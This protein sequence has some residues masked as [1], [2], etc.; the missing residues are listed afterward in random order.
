[1][2]WLPLALSY[3]KEELLGMVRL[4]DGSEIGRIDV[5]DCRSTPQVE[6]W[7]TAVIED[8]SRFWINSG[9]PLPFDR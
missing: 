8:Q 7:I 4:A 6:L 5:E 2:T 3:Q 1:M 9:H